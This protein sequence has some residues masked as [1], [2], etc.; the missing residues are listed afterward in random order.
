[1]KSS[2]GKI[3]CGRRSQEAFRSATALMGEY[4]KSPKEAATNV[5]DEPRTAPN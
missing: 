2:S 1:L 3:C 5:D 4:S